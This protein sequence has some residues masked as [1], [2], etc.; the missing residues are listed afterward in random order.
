MTPPPIPV[1]NVRGT[2]R[3]AGRRVGEACADAIR[4]EVAFPEDALPDGRSREEQLALAGLYRHVTAA[5]YPWYMD[6]IEGAAEAAGVDARALFA[7]MIEEIWYEPHG[8][9]LQGRCTDMVAVPP[10]TAGGHALVAHNND[11]PRSYQQNLVAIEWAIEGDPTVF[12]IGNGVWMSA[13]WN[14]AGLSFTGNELAPLDEKI[15]IPREIQFRSML[16]QPTHR[17]GASARRCVDDRASSLQQRRRDVARARP[18]TSRAR[19]PTAELTEPRTSAVMLVHTN[20]YVSDSM[21]QYEGDPD[22]VT[23]LRRAVPARE[24]AAR[25][26]RS[27]A[28]SPSR[29]C[30]TMLADHE[31]APDCLCRHPELYGGEYLSATAFWSIADVTEMRITFGRGNP[32]DSTT[33]EYRFA[34]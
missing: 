6:E 19:R 33:Q 21:L 8:R 4:L 5:A 18:R 31:G 12:S 13:G 24:R 29:R 20:H 22:Y 9:K 23:A 14:S 7:C 30:V 11:M 10:A 17:H 15:G 28:R 1:L 2:H 16:R 34:T 25:G 26:R 3:E 32:C 27:R